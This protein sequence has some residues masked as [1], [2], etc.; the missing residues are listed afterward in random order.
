M[1]VTEFEE[2]DNGKLLKKLKKRFAAFIDVTKIRPLVIFDGF[3][4]IL[5]E[6]QLTDSR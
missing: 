6:I 4:L 2:E 1:Y 5:F 3:R